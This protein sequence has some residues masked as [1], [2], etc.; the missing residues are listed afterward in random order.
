MSYHSIIQL[1]VFYRVIL[2]KKQPDKKTD[3]ARI[4][5]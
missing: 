4:H 3:S 1:M 2:Y 5:A